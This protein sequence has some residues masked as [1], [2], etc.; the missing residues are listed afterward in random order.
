MAA[1]GALAVGP[2]D[3]ASPR[4]GPAGCP[5]RNAAVA[6]PRL[7]HHGAF[8]RPR[9]IRYVLPTAGCAVF[10][11]SVAVPT[12]ALLAR[13]ALDGERPAGGFTLTGRQWG[14][15]GRSVGLAA[16]ATVT[17]LVVSIPGAYVVGRLGRLSRRPLL[18][19][20]LIAPLLFPP[21][22][23]VFGWQKLLPAAFSGGLQCV[24]VWALWAYP[25]PA[26]LIGSGW[27]RF[28]R[29]IYE[30]ALLDAP[31]ASAFARAVLPRLWPHVVLSALV[32]FILFLGEYGVP[33]ACGMMIYA[34]ELLGWSM[35]SRFPIDTLWPSWPVAVLILAACAIVRV[36][37]GRCFAENDTG[38]ADASA[39]GASASLTLLA[40][41]CVGVAAIVPTVALA[42]DLESAS[43]IGTAIRTYHGELLG[44]L[45]VTGSSGAI[46][47]GMGVC[48]AAVRRLRRPVLL[49]TIAFGALP[50]AL[51]GEAILSAYQNVPA[52]Y[53]HW[54]II[55][56]GFVARFGWIGVSAMM[57]AL[58]AAPEELDWQARTDGADEAGVSLHIHAVLS[59]PTLLFGACL[60]AALSL[61]ELPTSTLVR[62]P[63]LRLIAQT[64]MEKFHRFE[65][66][67]LISLSL[68]LV[69]ATVP[70]AVLL[71]VVL[72]RVR[73][74]R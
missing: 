74:L 6:T 15:L 53:N 10:L 62:V 24:G 26:L 21:M 27:S 39:R 45:A 64:L 36:V 69:M 48:V 31:P 35:E 61:S 37:W 23:Y 19:A 63:S 55:I 57:L 8:V 17:S 72:R 40:V 3:P 42:A 32:L 4:E 30:T 29:A 67:M 9:F 66:D 28:G 25:I 33:H 43:V 71:A 59:W 46:V 50:G 13:C 70:A 49:W 5:R 1:F 68:C 16:L 47:V 11:L 7:G 65:D 51:V 22:V 60:V 56:L 58:R 12:I 2:Y 73:S 44:S 54:W 18:V 20:I 41:V 14:L 34:T 52:I 38:T